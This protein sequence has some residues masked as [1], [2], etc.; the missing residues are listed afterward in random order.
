[1]KNKSLTLGIGSISVN[2]KPHSARYADLFYSQFYYGHREILLNYLEKDSDLLLCGILQHGVRQ[3]GLTPYPEDSQ[4]FKTPRLANWR[5]SPLWV[6]S[7]ET[8]THLRK[9][10]ARGNI[11]AIG[12]PW[13]YMTPAVANQKFDSSDNTAKKFVV[14][15]T[16]TQIGIVVNLNEFQIRDR[17]N[18]W[19]ELADFQPLTVC[20][21]WIEFLDPKWQKVCKEEGV[22]IACAGIGTTDPVW[23]Q[24]PSRLS[25][26]YKLRDIIS[27]HTHCIFEAFSSGIFYAISMNKHVGL[28]AG[29]KDLPK[30]GNSTVGDWVESI[31]EMDHSWAAAEMPLIIDNFAD[32]ESLK[33]LANYLLGVDAVRPINELN[34][35]L[36]FRKSPLL[37]S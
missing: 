14:F 21:F 36:K 32:A 19:K 24:N 13:N 35:I 18:Y 37:V 5:R 30:Y 17:I 31:H 33:S 12:A 3:I 11:Q 27:E 22:A 28:F 9:L 34:D 8:V 26:L 16:H 2:I 25:F 1:M 4:D 29:P 20:L 15:P 23:A 6:Y 7:K 10:G